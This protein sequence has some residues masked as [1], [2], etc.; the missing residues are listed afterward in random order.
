M[1]VTFIEHSLDQISSVCLPEFLF[2]FFDTDIID[3]K[4]GL[5]F[6]YFN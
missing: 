3:F 1:T 4:V 2:F 6:S 5:K